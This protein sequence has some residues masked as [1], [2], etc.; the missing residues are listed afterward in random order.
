M[1]ALMLMYLVFCVWWLAAP[2]TV[3][4][5]FIQLGATHDVCRATDARNVEVCR[6]LI[7]MTR[8][9]AVYFFLILCVLGGVYRFAFVHRPESQVAGEAVSACLAAFVPTSIIAAFL[10]ADI[11][12]ASARDGS[13]P[14]FPTWWIIITNSP[15]VVTIIIVLGKEGWFRRNGQE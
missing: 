2:K 15:F 14:Y 5:T 12:I 6:S 3:L 1:K 10:Y 4:D 11:S 8:F 9:A 7:F 13:T